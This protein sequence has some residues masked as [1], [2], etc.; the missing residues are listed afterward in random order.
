[1]SGRPSLL[2]LA[3]SLPF[4][5]HSGVQSRT[6]NVVKQLQQEFDVTLLPFARRN[7]QKTAE[8]RRDARDALARELF[9]VCDPV[10]IPAEQSTVRH[11]ADHVRSV[12]LGRP[13]TYH[14]YRAREY[15]RQL[16]MLLQDRTPDL[17]H[18]DSV[19]LAG[20]LDVLPDV[21][22][23]CTHHD[24]ESELL[25]RKA[26]QIK[27]RVLSTYVRH[28]SRLV[29]QVERTASPRFDL[30]L[31]MS[32]LDAARLTALAP[33]TRT[34]VVPNGVDTEFFAPAEA[35]ERIPGRVVFMGPTFMFANRD[36]VDFLLFD[37]WPTIRNARPEATLELVGRNSPED[38][39][40]YARQSGVITAGYVPDVRPHLQ[41]AACSVVPIRIGGGT[42]IKILESWAMGAPV[43]STRIG[44]E[45]LK[46][47]DG[48]NI[49]IRDT[50]DE[51]AEAVLEVLA[52]GSLQERLAREG[53]RT[54]ERFYSWNSI[55]SELRGAYRD[56]I[57]PAL[58][59]STVDA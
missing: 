26:R 11:L 53:R 51:I 29:E 32:D 21:P 6:Y 57:A 23:T 37:V 55:G 35:V 38:R 3:Q 4:P 14:T 8:A 49:L 47:S 27:S 18:L 1:M 30:N 43:V 17:I 34:M 20:F 58:Q 5:P 42:R 28:Q 59:C 36:A 40:R 22:V 39:A 25:A 10:P 2:F 52:H 46:T 33:D 45:G 12:L 7:H 50:A 16:E 13:Y 24:V 41:Q 44:C 56:L 19:D 15:D 48:E 9:R 31:M 54:V